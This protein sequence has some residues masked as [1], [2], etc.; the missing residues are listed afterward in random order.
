[1]TQEEKS[2]KWDGSYLGQYPAD[3]VKGETRNKIGCYWKL[4][5]SEKISFYCLSKKY[6]SSFNNIL[7]ECKRCCN[8]VPLGTHTIKIGKSLYLILQVA[9]KKHTFQVGSKSVTIELVYED[10]PLNKY[11]IEFI[12]EV[13]HEKI[14]NLLAFRYIMAIPRTFENHIHMRLLT[15]DKV[16][17]YIPISFL[18][19]SVNFTSTRE[20]LPATV[21]SKWFLRQKKITSIDADTVD[22]LRRAIKRLIQ[23][24][25]TNA[26]LNQRISAVSHFRTEFERTVMRIDKEQIWMSSFV[27]QN[28]LSKI[29]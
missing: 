16:D 15:G 1:M 20:R 8:L 9:T 23:L 28:I 21:Y 29:N 26:T 4:E 18:E 10:I 24:P 2:I 19:S 13:T 7:D 22:K 14:E 3:V 17:G 6:R 5:L 27:I 12:D 25:N 11:P